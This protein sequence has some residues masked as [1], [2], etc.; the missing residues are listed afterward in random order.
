MNKSKATYFSGVLFL[1]LAAFFW[2]TAFV[3][4]SDAM[5]NIGPMTFSALRS[6]LGGI[7]LIPIYIFT[8]RG[9]AKEPFRRENIKNTLT[10][11]L[12]CGVIMFF[13]M[14]CQQVGMVHASAGKAAFIT[15][16]Y[17]IFVPI[18]GL[19][20]K[21]RPSVAVWVGAVIALIGFYLLNITGDEGFGLGFWEILVLIC[22]FFFTFHI[23]AVEKYGSSLN[24]ALLSSMQFIVTG[25]IS[26]AFSFIDTAF[27]GY[28]ALTAEVLGS[29]WF[30]IFYMGVFSCGV[31]YTFQI[32]GQQRV[33][34]ATASLLMSFESVFAVLAAW[35][36]SGD[37]LEAQQ[38]IGCALIFGAIVLSQL[39]TEM[40][41]RKKDISPRSKKER[42]G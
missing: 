11:G 3:A 38:I 31:A 9:K 20:F 8:A 5:E 14:N 40:L 32:V 23:L 4:Q 33:P 16:L 25:I 42:L 35:L 37:L 19:F 13:A 41:T 34:S 22:A 10:A 18:F 36:I 26:F 27:L 2:G 30:N 7:I 17:I 15:A 12:V 21:K 28:P 6:T 1:L 24:A 39:P 29:V